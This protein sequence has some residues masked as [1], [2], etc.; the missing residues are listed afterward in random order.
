M[1][2]NLKIVILEQSLF[3]KETL[4]SK[5]GDGSDEVRCVDTPSAALLSVIHWHPDVLI[6]SVEVGEING[7]DL[8]MILKLMP[9]YASMPVIIV[10]SGEVDAIKRKAAS[11]GADCYVLKDRNIIANVRK[12]IRSL[13]REGSGS[14][15]GMLD[16]QSPAASV[17]LAATAAEP[18]AGGVLVVD[19]SAVMRRVIRNMLQSAGVEEI[20]EAANGAAGL[21]L[22]KER[23]IGLVLTDWNMPVMTGLEFIKAIRSESQFEDLPVV[24]VTTEGG[25]KERQLAHDAGATAHLSKPFNT[26]KIRDIVTRFTAPSAA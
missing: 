24:M 3:I 17:T 2:R 14:V 23:E 26:E 6:T 5:L 8:C 19:D 9:D 7:F 20:H 10:S 25:G 18:R 13:C 22:L 21:A 1:L 4:L 11:V 16:E 12:A 15:E